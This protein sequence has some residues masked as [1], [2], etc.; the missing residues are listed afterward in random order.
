[1][2]GIT[3]TLDGVSRVRRFYYEWRDKR[4]LRKLLSDP[5]YPDGRSLDRLAKK[6]GRTEDDARRLLNEMSATRF[7]MAD[8]REGWRLRR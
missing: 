1:M 2:V 8:G 4:V 6:T 3:D 5:K 7:T